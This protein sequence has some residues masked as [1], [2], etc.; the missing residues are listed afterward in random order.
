MS[1]APGEATSV[2]KLYGSTLAQ[3]R[4]EIIVRLMGTRGVGWEGDSFSKDEI[5]AAKSWLASKAVTIYGGTNEVQANIISKR[6]LG[7]PD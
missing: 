6:G 2:F 5:G 7:L 1:K 4:Q 3:D